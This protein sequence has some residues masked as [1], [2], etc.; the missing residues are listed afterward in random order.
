LNAWIQFWCLALIWGS[1][2]LLMKFALQQVGP[3]WLSSVRILFAA[4]IFVVYLLWSRRPM[5]RTRTEWFWLAFV[6]VVNTTIPFALVAWGVQYVDTGLST[7]LMATV[8]FLSLTLAH[9]TLHDERLNVVKGVGLLMG[10]VGVGLL[11]TRVWGGR[12]N[13][14]AGVL[15]MLASTLCY[16]VCL[17]A[18][19]RFLR[20][21][22]P[23][24]IAGV[25]ISF[26]ALACLPLLFVVSWPVFSEFNTTTWL[27]TLSL[28]T[29][30]TGVAY[31][32][33][34]N[35]V[36]VWGPRASL[37][38]YAMPPIGVILG[39]VVLGETMDWRLVVGGAVILGGIVL[40]R[41]GRWPWQKE[42]TQ[43]G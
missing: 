11:A 21:V 42:A 9:F 7:L 30:H 38:T 3:L 39:V 33:F 25:S 1:S 17:V 6:G 15:A 36:G 34:Y 16:A 31:F 14:L 27:S 2:F 18:I 13:A 29:V 41:S 19:R 20:E 23:L 12:A 32:L 40:A 22:Q 26:G 35:L 5:P 37:V 28:G 43:V 4:V 24:V 10:F 8:P